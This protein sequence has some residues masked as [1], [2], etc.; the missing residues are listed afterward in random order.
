MLLKKSV[1]LFEI[2]C[3]AFNFRRRGRRGDSKQRRAKRLYCAASV[4]SNLPKRM[5]W[6]AAVAM[7][8]VVFLGLMTLATTLADAQRL[9]AP[10]DDEIYCL[11]GPNNLLHVVQMAK[12]YNDSKT[13]VDKAVKISPSLVLQNFQE[14]MRKTSKNPS[15]EQVLQFVNENFDPEGSEFEPWQP[16]DWHV[17]PQILD[18]IQDDEYQSFAQ[19]LHQRW[20]DLGRQIKQ[21]VQ[22]NPKKYSLLYLDKPFIVPGGRFRE[23]YYWDS[24]WT[25]QGLLVSEMFDTVKGNCTVFH[26]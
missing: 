20:K 1:S 26:I 15:K 3:R 23:M 17:D 7:G 24:Y 5:D 21:D 10:C 2:L 4:V 12:L 11:P 16:Q 19:D 13:F 14:L 6:R 18:Q 25:I 9:P 22:R 8:A